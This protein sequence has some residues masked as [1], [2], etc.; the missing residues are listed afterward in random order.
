M[1]SNKPQ[2]NTKAL[3]SPK[4]AQATPTQHGKKPN[5]QNVKSSGYGQPKANAQARNGSFV[6]EQEQA[7]NP[8]TNASKNQKNA[9]LSYN[10]ARQNHFGQRRD[11]GAEVRRD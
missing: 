11:S 4:R 7:S 3:K 10:A 2:T 8:Q 1:G 6:A 9:M 5:V